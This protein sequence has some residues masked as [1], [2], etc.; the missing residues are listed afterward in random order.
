MIHNLQSIDLEALPRSALLV[1][2]QAAE[3]LRTTAES[4]SVARCTGRPT[5]PY[6][7]MGKSIRYRA[8]DL[9]DYI[10]SCTRNPANRGDT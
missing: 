3:V 6:V 2:K 8:G 1:P 5:P 9:L 7:Q 4:L 10:E